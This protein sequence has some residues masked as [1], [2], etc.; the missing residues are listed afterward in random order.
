MN[1]L[2]VT[3]MKKRNAERSTLGAFVTLPIE[4]E[5]A[6]GNGAGRARVIERL[7]REIDRLT[8]ASADMPPMLSD[9]QNLLAECLRVARRVVERGESLDNA[10]SKTQENES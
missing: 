3:Q 1:C 6:D 8:Q 10:R 5:L 2:R 4:K 9:R 7:Q